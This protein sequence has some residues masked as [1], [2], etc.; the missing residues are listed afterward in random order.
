M[1]NLKNAARLGALAA[2]ASLALTGCV[3]GTAAAPEASAQTGLPQEIKSAGKLRIGLSPDFPPMEF[4]DSDK[5]LAGVD[6]DLQQKLGEVLGIQIEVV[7]SPFDQL[8]NSVQT[9]RVDV[10]M[11]GISDTL[12]RQKTADFV[13]YFKSQGRLYTSGS[14]AAEFTKQSDA[15]GKK[16][17]VS[18]KTDYFE[19]VKS[20][21]K[22]LCVDKGL[23]EITILATDSGAAARLQ[24]EQGRVDLA[25]QGAENLAYF[26]KTEPGK[27]QPVLDPLPAKPFGILVKMNSTQLT[28][29]IKD[30]L[31]KIKANGDYQKILDKWGLG[32]GAMDAEVNGVK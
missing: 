26:A 23:P 28:N 30:A 14:R 20:L 25:A 17:A 15:C 18:G 10:V 27:Y 21:S 24:I 22:T 29:A 4:R 19:Q 32:Y 9:G 16:L 3:S 5:K 7:E 1:K 13:D 2:V 6:I 12:E 11:S 31:T 8:I